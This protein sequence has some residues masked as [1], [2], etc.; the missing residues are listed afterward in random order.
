MSCLKL[1]LSCVSI[2][3][4][5]ALALDLPLTFPFYKPAHQLDVQPNFGLGPRSCIS[6]SPV[7]RQQNYGRTQSARMGQR[8]MS[9]TLS[10]NTK[11]HFEI[12]TRTYVL[13]F[14]Y[15]ISWIF[16]LIWHYPNLP[17]VHPYSSFPRLCQAGGASLWLSSQTSRETKAPPLDSSRAADTAL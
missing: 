17:C 10:G 3:H 12:E 16:T 6:H 1:L 9:Q 5:V 7:N 4:P 13:P 14:T 15:W 11:V 8:V 2:C